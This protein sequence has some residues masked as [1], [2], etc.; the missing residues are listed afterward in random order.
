[1]LLRRVTLT[2]VAA[3]GAGAL[4]LAVVELLRALGD[5]EL[6]T[7]LPWYLSRAGGITAYLLLSASTLVGLTLS[8]QRAGRLPGRSASFVLH[9]H[10]SWLA[11]A[12]VGLHAGVLLLDT[13]EP[14][15]VADLLLPLAAPYRPVAVALGVTAMY[16]AVVLT[17]SFYLRAR[18]GQRARRTLHYASFGLYVL[19]TLH[20]L[21]AGSSTG[22]LWMRALYVT[23]ALAVLLLT[24][25]RLLLT[26]RRPP[27]VAP[28][29]RP[30]A[31]PR[32]PI[33]DPDWSVWMP[34]ERRMPQSMAS[35]AV[36]IE[37]P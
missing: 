1:M 35:E 33:A 32:A 30:P 37:R 16:L 3:V 22:Q 26:R 10:L 13:Y 17:V 27:S 11:L 21:L 20:G 36:P 6:A 15:N 19:A 7:R 4:V 18:I 28:A 25:W 14:F 9:E 12:A 2:A 29:R 34:P 5:E 31:R 8:A 24:G 23:S